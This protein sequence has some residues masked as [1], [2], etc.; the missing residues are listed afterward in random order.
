MQSFRIMAW[1]KICFRQIM[2]F[3]LAFCFLPLSLNRF[4]MVGYIFCYPLF[5]QTFHLQVNFHEKTSI[6]VCILLIKIYIFKKSNLSY[7][8]MEKNIF[9]IKITFTLFFRSSFNNFFNVSVKFLMLTDFLNIS[10]EATVRF[11]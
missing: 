2:T 3:P 9:L 5:L 4:L 6:F 11:V 7:Y 8:G 1:G 10:I